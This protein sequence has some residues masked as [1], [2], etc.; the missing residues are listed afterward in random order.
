MEE[1]IN[2]NTN[3]D[4]DLKSM[5]TIEKILM[6]QKL[7]N[8]LS[9]RKK[10]L[11]DIKGKIFSEI[12]KKCFNYFEG[13]INNKRAFDLIL[14]SDIINNK[15]Y[16]FIKNAKYI[17]EGLY[18]PAYNFYFLLQNDNS[19]MMKLSELS[20]SNQSY[21][22]QLSDFFV[23]FL[24]TNIIDSSF[25]SERLILMIYLLLEK[26]ILK[27]IKDK[28]FEEPFLI[29]VFKSLT[30]KID[31]WNYLGSI[32]NKNIL[33]IAKVRT[34]LSVNI[35][36]VNQNMNSKGNNLYHNLNISINPFKSDEERKKLFDSNIKTKFTKYIANNEEN[37]PLL[38]RTKRI[39][40][41]SRIYNEDIGLDEIKE[42]ES[43]D[44]DYEFIDENGEIKDIK[45]SI[46]LFKKRKT[47]E[48][49]PNE[50]EK[51]IK[52]KF[53]LNI[54]NNLSLS[55]KQKSDDSNDKDN[56]FKTL[57]ITKIKSD[58]SSENFEREKVNIEAFF[59]DN[60]ITKDKLF[61]YSCIAIYI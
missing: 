42:T 50:Q 1:N 56:L 21:C 35:Y 54:D 52:K 11:N 15:K 45:K 14:N 37:K 18:E 31:I 40:N 4:S 12:D 19:L 24:Y 28:Y 29:N 53:F 32:L 5:S 22:E 59:D 39:V 23:H 27:K 38:R 57:D 51:N 60:N 25:N 58:S 13:K 26:Q 30:R 17:L 44:E 20:Q 33:K 48:I 34:I 6:L 41:I 36:E 7:L 10:A 49:T 46:I 9:S 2:Q 16:I 47:N 3:K 61:K 55:D 8:D 43:E